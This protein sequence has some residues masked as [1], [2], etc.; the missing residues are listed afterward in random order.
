MTAGAAGEEATAFAGPTAGAAGEGETGAAGAGTPAPPPLPVGRSAGLFAPMSDVEPAGLGTLARAGGA[1]GRG[2]APPVGFAGGGR[3]AGAAAVF[4]T[5]GFAEEPLEAPAGA[6]P[7]GDGAGATFGALFG[8]AAAGAGATGDGTA[9]VSA[10]G[11]RLSAS[12]ISGGSLSS[13]PGAAMAL[14]T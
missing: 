2:K 6:A 3:G 5:A 1:A 14:D 13:P 8:S 11:A 9:E 7:V 10:A 4:G 12:P